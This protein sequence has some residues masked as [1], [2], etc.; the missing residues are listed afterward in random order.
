MDDQYARLSWES[1]VDLVYGKVD[2]HFRSLSITDNEWR[3]SKMKFPNY[4]ERIDQLE[5]EAN[6]SQLEKDK[7]W[8]MVDRWG[9]NHLEIFKQIK[10]QRARGPFPEVTEEDVKRAATEFWQEE[11]RANRGEPRGSGSKRKGAVGKHPKGEEV[12]GDATHHGGADS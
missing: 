11:A 12:G 10:A 1:M 7:F 6:P 3:W 2:E 5:Q 4:F 8:D 9:K